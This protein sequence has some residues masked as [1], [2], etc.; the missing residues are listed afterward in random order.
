MLVVAVLVGF[1]LLLNA[2]GDDGGDDAVTTGDEPTTEQPTDDTAVDGDVTTTTAESVVTT[3]TEAEASLRAP[4]EVRVLVLNGGGPAGTA[5]ATT[6]AIGGA[7][8]DMGEATNATVQLETTAVYFAEGYEADAVAVAEVL[9]KPGDVVAPMPDPLPG[10]GS[11]TANVVVV[12]GGDTPPVG[13]ETGDTT[14]T[15]TG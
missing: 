1:L 2:G 7:G 5:A 15:T 12:L 6:E 10:P 8:Y 9:G 11:E 14:T 3:T 4:G 13:S